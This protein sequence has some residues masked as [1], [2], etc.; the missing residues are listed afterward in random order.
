MYV[1]S[2]NACPHSEGNGKCVVS[3]II[4]LEP[5]Q[6]RHRIVDFSDI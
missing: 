3:V 2:W 4:N 5:G 1:G 6:G